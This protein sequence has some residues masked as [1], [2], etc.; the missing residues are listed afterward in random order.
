MYRGREG[1]K[2]KH[3][4]EAKKRF[5]GFLAIVRRSSQR[6]NFE[7]I[8]SLSVRRQPFGLPSNG[9]VYEKVCLDELSN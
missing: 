3:N 5:N 2:M 9:G 4:G 6:A 7:T 8:V 1:S